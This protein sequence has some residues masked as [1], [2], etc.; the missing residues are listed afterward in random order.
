MANV[1]RNEVIAV[2][3]Q[4]AVSE[5]KTMDE[6]LDMSLSQRRLTMLLLVVFGSVALVLAAVGLY[7]VMAYS[8]EQRIQEL[9]IRRALG[10]HQRDIVR[11]IVGRALCLTLM[12]AIFGLGG[13]LALTRTMQTLLF[14]VSSTDPA[15]FATVLLVFV[16][17]ALVSSSIPVWR[18][19]RI[20]PMSALRTN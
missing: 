3:G 12:G 5:I 7:G 20:D 4:Q 10:A 9:G 17:V 8:V 6:I 1:V 15:I 14:Q 16:L 11:L 2:D 13:A 19:L 18:A